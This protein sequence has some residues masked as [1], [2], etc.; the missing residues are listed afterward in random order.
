M[1]IIKTFDEAEEKLTV[2]LEGRL[3][4]AAAPELEESLSDLSGVKDL[5]FDFIK[6]E[7]VTSAGLRVLLGAQKTMT[8]KG[9]MVLR[10]VND[11]IMEVFEITGFADVLTVEQE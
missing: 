7:Y 10:N 8:G 9:T 2:E 11:A 6:L 3:D 1:T 4:T 5:V